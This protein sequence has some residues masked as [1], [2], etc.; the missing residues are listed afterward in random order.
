MAELLA[1]IYDFLVIDM[2]H[3]AI[4]FETALHLI[5][6]VRASRSICQVFLRVDSA[7]QVNM[8][9][10]LDLGPDAL[11][12]PTVRTLEE[13]DKI[14]NYSRYPHDL[15]TR[16]TAFP[17]IRASK[18]G[19]DRDYLKQYRAKTLL[20]VQ[21]EDVSGVENASG[22]LGTDGIDGVFIGPLDLSSS[23]G[24]PGETS[25]PIVGHAMETI[26]NAA[27][28][29]DKLLC[30]F[31]LPK[32]NVQQMFYDKGYDMV[33]TGSDVTLVRDAAISQVLKAKEL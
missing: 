30:S 20:L 21:L 2:E 13:A 24:H 3:S 9:R 15:G 1:H 8:K 27:K 14:V 7:T 10:A 16:G 29:N 28:A 5:Q 23:Y 25:H 18:W 11:I 31:A 4:S 26:E 22:I 17:L 6:A 19:L 33:A 12:L 32:T